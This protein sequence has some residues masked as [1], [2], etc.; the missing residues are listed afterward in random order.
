MDFSPSW[1]MWG[2][3]YWVLCKVLSAGIG[4]PECSGVPLAIQRFLHHGPVQ[5]HATPSTF[6][7]NATSQVHTTA[8][9]RRPGRAL[10]PRESHSRDTGT[11]A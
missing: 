4:K 5:S 8:Q 1:K 2:K 3:T 6:L 7:V 11:K 9:R 10:R